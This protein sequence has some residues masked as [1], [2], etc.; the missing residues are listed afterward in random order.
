V[1]ESVRVYVSFHVGL[2]CASESAGRRQVDSATVCVCVCVCECVCVSVYVRA[3]A[4]VRTVVVWEWR[5]WHVITKQ[6]SLLCHDCNFLLS[7][8]ELVCVKYKIVQRGAPPHLNMKPKLN[9]PP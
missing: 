9:S 1:P 4:C 3:C 5:T 7:V 2:L 6:L 8:K